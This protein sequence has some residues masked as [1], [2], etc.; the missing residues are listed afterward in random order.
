M[1][2]ILTFPDRC[3]TVDRQEFLQDGDDTLQFDISGEQKQ[4]QKYTFPLPKNFSALTSQKPRTKDWSNQELA[5]LYR[6][7]RLLDLAGISNS[8]DRGVSDEGDPWFLFC[9]AADEVFI[10]FCRIDGVYFLDNPSIETPLRGKDF[11]QLVDAFVHR[12]LRGQGESPVD[13]NH[14]VV[15]L[16]RN[17]KVFLHPSTMLAALVW[18]LFLESEDLVMVLPKDVGEPGVPIDNLIAASSDFN[19][20][21]TFEMHSLWKGSSG[22]ED[23]G[24]RNTADSMSMSHQLRD[25][26]SES[27]TKFGHNTYIIGLSA[28]AISL[29]IM[30]DKNLPDIDDVGLEDVLDQLN[31]DSSAEQSSSML[32]LFGSNV[33]EALNFLSVLQQVFADATMPFTQP[34]EEPADAGHVLA[35]LLVG[36]ETGLQAI[37]GEAVELTENWK[38]SEDAFSERETGQT[39]YSS[40]SNLPQQ[41]LVD[42]DAE[43]ISLVLSKLEGVDKG[44]L[45]STTLLRSFKIDN[46]TIYATFD[47]SAADFEKTNSLLTSGSSKISATKDPIEKTE[48]DTTSVDYQA[49]QKATEEAYKFI[50]YL[51]DKEDDLE[52]IVLNGELIFVD[53]DVFNVSSVET[54]VMSWEVHDGDIISIIGLQS[55]Y[56][57]FSLLA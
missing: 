12:K 49:R 29:G 6:V 52:V 57:D 47:I 39:L 13:C 41:A 45:F 8:I 53:L 15:R 7:K 11:N 16:E 20:D 54:Y 1:G 46:S 3:D 30:S 10:H 43:Q 38:H 5:H 24:G 23:E 4:G 14:K 9:D 51:F 17:G 35:K 56:A 21:A 50:S 32:S 27:D 42:R 37:K 34:G 55:D 18:T 33:D 22:I 36:I 19:Q 40:D 25:M 48:V 28:I 26:L 2:N 44:A 31:T